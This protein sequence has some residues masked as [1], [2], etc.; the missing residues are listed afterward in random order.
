[1]QVTR[2]IYAA[3]LLVWVITFQLPSELFGQSG[4][5]SRSY[6]PV[7]QTQNQVP[8]NVVSGTQSGKVFKTDQ[9]WRQQLTPEE[10]RVTRQKGTEQ[11]FTGQYWNSK[12]DGIYTC[13]CCGQALFDSRTKFK[14][15]TG[16]PSFYQPI[17]PS[18]Y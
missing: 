15:G 9:Q 2:L 5:G 11:P 13:K 4:S 16:W 17:A 7:P 18:C 1:M 12:Q 10:Y 3:V 14:S 8:G 6:A